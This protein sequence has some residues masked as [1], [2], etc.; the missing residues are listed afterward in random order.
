MQILKL[1]GRDDLSDRELTSHTYQLYLKEYLRCV[2]GIDDNLQRLLDFLRDEDLIENTLIIY[3]SDQGM[4]LGEHDYIDKRWML[5]E[6][7]R[8]PL[9]VHWPGAK[10]G[11]R[12]DWMVNNVDFAPTLLAAAGV[13]V[14]D[15][16][17]GRSFLGALEGQV[18]PADWRK[19][20]YYRYWM[21]MAHGHNNPA[22]FG[23]RT[24]RHKLIFYYGIDY[25][26]LHRG[27]EVEKHGENRFWDDT[28]AAWE[29]YDLQRDPHEMHNLYRD[30]D[31]AGLVSSLKAELRQLRKRLG[32]TDTDNP[33]I[34]EII[35]AHWDE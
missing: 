1:T 2:K 28:P 24:A 8:L 17:Q 34:R 35:D 11:T 5:E 12:C 26:N 7:I 14:P 22:H 29:L 10:P 25:K 13:D 4:M 27:K 18:R 20:T 30:P 31:Y 15:Y 9:I 21:H 16:M 3:T 32:D 6:S 23:I 19:A 33:R